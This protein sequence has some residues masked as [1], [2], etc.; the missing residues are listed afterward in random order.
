MANKANPTERAEAAR[1][2]LLAL[3]AEKAAKLLDPATE[4]FSTHGYTG[5][6]L[7]RILASARMS[8]GQAYYYVT[9]KADLYLAVCERAFAPIAEVAG[10]V[11]DTL[12]DA[13]TFW[14]A[15]MGLIEKMS[16]LG[17]E[18]GPISDLGRTVYES[19]ESEAALA[20]LIKR[21]EAYLTDW[22]KLGQR[23]GAVR[24]DMPDELLQTSLLGLLSVMDRWF[25][26][27]CEGY[28]RPQL[29]AMNRAAFQMLR[30]AASP[31]D[32]S[33]A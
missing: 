30:A 4:E 7:N 10:P 13:A 16:V 8:K 32:V 17:Q 22:I 27:N 15:V 2:R 31:P 21:V 18:T 1:G 19:P 12:P 11:P 6:S 24:T 29:E 25:S 3:P 26:K 5:A 23:S 9:G 20:P 33:N 28:S 14:R